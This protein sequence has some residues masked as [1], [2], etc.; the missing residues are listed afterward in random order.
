[1]HSASFSNIHDLSKSSKETE[2]LGKVP[3][4]EIRNLE[5][6]L[7]QENRTLETSLVKYI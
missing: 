5:E 1:M 4:K 6:L 2:T 7:L 3:E